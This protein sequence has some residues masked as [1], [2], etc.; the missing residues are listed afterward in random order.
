MI[1]LTVRVGTE[2]REGGAASWGYWPCWLV[3]D[4]LQLGEAPKAGLKG[5]ILSH[6]TQLLTCIQEDRPVVTKP[7]L[8]KQEPLLSSMCFH[9][10]PPFPFP[11]SF[12][13]KSTKAR[14]PG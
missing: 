8:V 6:Q 5:A 1:Q 13:E 3:V 10:A 11:F 12:R 9:P 14:L 7:L 2:G 4:R